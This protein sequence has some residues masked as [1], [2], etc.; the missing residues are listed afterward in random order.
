MPYTRRLPS[1]AKTYPELVQA[2]FDEF[3]RVSSTDPGAPR[4][5]EEALS[6]SDYS[7]VTVVWERWKDLG[8]ETRSGIILDAYEKKWGREKIMKIASALGLT[9][10]EAD[11]LGLKLE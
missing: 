4:I 9:Q 7:H 2:I 10:A 8:P 1:E 3:D 5:Y 6:R 11:R